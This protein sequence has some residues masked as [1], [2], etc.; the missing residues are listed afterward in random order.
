MITIGLTTW[1]EH[2]TLVKDEKRAVSLEEYAAYFPVVEVDTF[3]YGL[4]RLET[5]Q[6]WQKQVPRNFQFIVKANKGLTKHPGENLT[7]KL[8]QQ[9]FIDF[10]KSIGSL[11][12]DKQLKTILLQFP[13]F[14][15]AT[16]ENVAYLHYIREQLVGLPLSL[17][18]RNQSWFE[19]GIKESL[20]KFCLDKQ[21]TLV[22]VDEPTNTLAS[23][24]FVLT[25][26]NPE[27]L[28]V[29]LHGRNE[30]G[31]NASG[32]EW[33]KQRTLYKYNLAELTELKEQLVLYEQD[34]KD[35]CVIF[36][37]NAGGDAAP[38]ALELQRIMQVKFDNLGKKPPEQLDLF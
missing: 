29:R 27:L 5:V 37:N 19:E 14:F 33:R 35:I 1:S 10:K 4:P 30:R 3:F 26:T 7:G 11:I 32:K 25:K 6:K 20:I 36:N 17:E 15:R 21:Y 8:L 38:N 12:R 28:L 18:L 34:V 16:K 2:T 23:I 9:R 31:W 24:P 13:P 22:A